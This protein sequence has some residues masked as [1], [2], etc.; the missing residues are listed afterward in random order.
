MKVPNFY[1]AAQEIFHI[2]CVY[3]YIE[4]ERG[5]ER[6]VCVYMIITV[7]ICIYIYTYTCIHADL[8]HP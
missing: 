7:C 5:I 4:R 3:I 6:V 8:K 1:S 2:L